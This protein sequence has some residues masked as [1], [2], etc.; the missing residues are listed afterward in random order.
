MPELFSSADFEGV[1]GKGRLVDAFAY[2]DLVG[3]NLALAQ[4][5]AEIAKVHEYQ[6]GQELY[7][8]G[9][10]GK[11]YL[12]F[13]LS[14]EFD[15]LD[16]DNRIATLG[17]GQVVGEFPILEPSSNYYVTS[18]ARGNSVVALVSAGQFESIATEEYPELWRNMAKMIA[19]RLRERTT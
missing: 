7:R 6:E 10:P 9:E 15:L 18:R 12:Y 5:L 4:R 14:G 2:Q 17:S 19:R 11:G 8:Q 1:A 3:N 16:K 13:I